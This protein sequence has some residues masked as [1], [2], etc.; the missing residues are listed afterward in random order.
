MSTPEKEIENAIIDYLRLKHWLV[1]RVHNV[2]QYD[3]H[4]GA[5]RTAGKGFIHGVADLC[6]MKECRLV[7]I[8]VKTP[9][10]KQSPAQKSFEARVKLEQFEYLLARS[11]D[12]VIAYCG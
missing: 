6:A 9:R 8:E 2:T 1:F 3:S 4:L 10:G 5:Y 11:I 12:D 7:W